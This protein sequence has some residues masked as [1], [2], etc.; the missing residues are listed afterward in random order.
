MSYNRII[1]QGNL[2]RDPELTF[3]AQN[4]AV[5]KFGM[6]VNKKLGKD[7]ADE[8][9]FVDVVA[10]GK[11]GEVINQHFSKGKP[12]LVEGRLKLEQWQAKDGTQRSKHVV[13]LDNF[14][15]VGGKNDTPARDDG[16]P[17]P[18]DENPVF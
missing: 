12:I 2:T 17:H 10:F 13:V 18:D 3:T 1:L 7:K 5:C 11:G 4:L 14:S 15:F 8:V 16:T 9:L 6:A